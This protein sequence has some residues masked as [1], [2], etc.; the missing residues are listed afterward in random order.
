MSGEDTEPVVRSL[1]SVF[2]P[3]TRKGCARIEFI[4]LVSQHRELISAFES[5]ITPQFHP[6]LFR[7]L[8]DSQEL[9]GVY[10]SSCVFTIG[11]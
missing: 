10:G 4:D 7:S 1:G 6:A 5:S 11:H 8:S 9:Y 2:Y 3:L